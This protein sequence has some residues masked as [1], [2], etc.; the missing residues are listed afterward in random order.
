M[1]LISVV[2]AKFTSALDHSTKLDVGGRM[3][4]LADIERVR[5]VNIGSCAVTVFW[6]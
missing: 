3:I 4:D 5:R 1:R 6:C 2:E